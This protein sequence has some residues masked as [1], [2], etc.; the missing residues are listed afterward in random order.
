MS[1]E[2]ETYC[3]MSFKTPVTWYMLHAKL[4][5]VTSTIIK[6][7]SKRQTR[8]SRDLVITAH[9][10]TMT[11]TYKMYYEIS[12]TFKSRSRNNL[13]TLM[14]FQ[15]HKIVLIG[16][17]L[18]AAAGFLPPGRIFPCVYQGVFFSVRVT[19]G[20]F[21]IPHLWIYVCVYVICLIFVYAWCGLCACV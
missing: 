18:W 21:L 14:R 12:I 19:W 9:P 20:H 13:W 7:H 6:V 8:A 17:L 3:L 2:L 4:T 1:K 5:G 16:C 11:S 15:T 10:D